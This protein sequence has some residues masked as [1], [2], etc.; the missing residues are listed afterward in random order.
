MAI[1][2]HNRD[3]FQEV[4]AF[5]RKSGRLDTLVRSL[6]TLNNMGNV[7]IMADFA[8]YSFFFSSDRGLCGGVIFH[9]SHDNGGDGS[10]P[11]YSVCVDKADGW[12]IHT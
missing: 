8:P 5:A 6:R 10:A 2:I 11:T 12:R 9:G 4:L 3:H 1:N 7:T